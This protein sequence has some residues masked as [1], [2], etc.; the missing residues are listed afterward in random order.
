ML[1]G[2][3]V[4]GKNTRT[5]FFVG[6]YFISQNFHIVSLRIETGGKYTLN[7]TDNVTS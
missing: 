2:G 4:M 5:S 7:I 3:K 6:C 1:S